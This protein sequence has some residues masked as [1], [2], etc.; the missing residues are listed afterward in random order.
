MALKI[1]L[2]LENSAISIY[3]PTVSQEKKYEVAVNICPIFLYYSFDLL[4][5]RNAIEH[6]YAVTI[7]I[8]CTLCQLQLCV[9]HM[10]IPK[11]NKRQR[12]KK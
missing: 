2:A 8:L 9:S 6:C 7:S 3:T 5:E 1:T 4:V 11:P 12:H 10:Y